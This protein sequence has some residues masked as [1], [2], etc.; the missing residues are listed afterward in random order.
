MGDVS[1][2][3]LPAA[4][5]KQMKLGNSLTSAA[6]LKQVVYSRKSMQEWRV[7]THCVQPLGHAAAHKRR[8]R[9]LAV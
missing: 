3:C 8:E 1:V 9:S 5:P 6:C 2:E 7:Q 4:A